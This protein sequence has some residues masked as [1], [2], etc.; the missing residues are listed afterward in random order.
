MQRE[1]DHQAL[2][3]MVQSAGWRSELLPWMLE[4]INR[5]DEMQRSP[6]MVDAMRHDAS[7]GITA[8]LKLLEWVYGQAREPNPLEIYRAGLWATLRPEQM[9]EPQPQAEAAAQRQEEPRRGYGQGSVA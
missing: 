2:R 5:W 4:W 3:I 6:R 9:E 8:F 1:S 7:G